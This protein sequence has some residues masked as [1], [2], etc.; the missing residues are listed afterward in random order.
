MALL[1]ARRVNPMV[2]GLLAI[3]FVLA[4]GSKLA[5]AKMH[6]ENFARWGYPAWFVYVVG[7]VEVAGA[8]LVVIPRTRFY[9]AVLLAA[10]MAG[11]VFTHL[12]SAE[13]AL[14]PPP[15]AL[16]VLAALAAWW[17]RSPGR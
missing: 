15:L 6:L 7:L 16:L 10:N 9:G 17:S 4:G 13:L 1:T 2:S 12:K 3:V 8:V 5:G 11:A 14:V